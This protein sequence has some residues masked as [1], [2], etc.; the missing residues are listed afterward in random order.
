MGVDTILHPRDFAHVLEATFVAEYEQREKEY[1]TPTIER[2]YCACGIFLSTF[3]A[4]DAFD[5]GISVIVKCSTCPEITCLR[6]GEAQSDADVAL[7]HPCGNGIERRKR[8]EEVEEALAFIRLKRG[9]HYQLCP[10]ESCNRKVELMEA[11]NHIVCVCGVGFCFIC[12]KEA[13][14]EGDHWTVGGCPRYNQPDD[15]R[16]EFDGDDEDSSSDSDEES[17]TAEN[18]EDGELVGDS[19]V[20]YENV[21]EDEDEDEDEEESEGMD[22]DGV[23]ITG[24]EVEDDEVVRAMFDFGG[25]SEEDE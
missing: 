14:G 24:E 1:K 17:E 22:V 7:S 10:R 15:P 9:K 5:E 18:A 13:D 3:V 4:Q 11:C 6:C 23:A 8:L 20:H 19:D 12:G 21:S 2:V 25:E 16:A